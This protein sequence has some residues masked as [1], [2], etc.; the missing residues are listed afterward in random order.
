M[1]FTEKSISS[2][3]QNSEL[4]ELI[5]CSLIVYKCTIFTKSVVTVLSDL[6]LVLVTQGLLDFT[7]IARDVGSGV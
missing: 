6:V 2:T 1:I 3:K 7:P 5:L 4:D